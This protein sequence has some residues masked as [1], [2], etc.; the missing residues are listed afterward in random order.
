MQTFGLKHRCQLII[1]LKTIECYKRLLCYLSFLPYT[2]NLLL[3]FVITL[4]V[5]IF[6]R[7][8][9]VQMLRHSS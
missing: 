5:A 8:Q 1:R 9:E 4:F 6:L 7:L 2:S 3:I